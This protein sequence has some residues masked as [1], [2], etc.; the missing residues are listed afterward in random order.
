MHCSEF[1]ITNLTK[2]IKDMQRL[3]ESYNPL[4]GKVFD[5]HCFLTNRFC[6]KTEDLDIKVSNQSQAQKT[7]V[8]HSYLSVINAKTIKKKIEYVRQ[9]KKIALKQY[10]SC[11]KKE[12]KKMTI[13]VD[14]KMI[15]TDWLFT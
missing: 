2:D 6:K 7:R 4:L 8:V 10:L 1:E 14:I 11:T 12:K 3:I 5:E 13:D 15:R 9:S